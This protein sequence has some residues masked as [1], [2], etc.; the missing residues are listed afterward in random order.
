MN[1]P[2][3]PWEII[4]YPLLAGGIIL[5]DNWPPMVYWSR[6][7]KPEVLL[8]GVAGVIEFYHWRQRIPLLSRAILIGLPMSLIAALV[9]P[10][11]SRMMYWIVLGIFLYLGLL[12]LLINRFDRWQENRKRH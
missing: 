4:L 11:N 5:W 2:L 12:G 10:G 9:M 8:W 1:D 7:I 6:L 3:E